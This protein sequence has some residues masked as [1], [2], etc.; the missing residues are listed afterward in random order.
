[1]ATKTKKVAA[2]PF[3]LFLILLVV[4]VYVLMGCGSSNCQLR[5]ANE[6]QSYYNTLP[7]TTSEYP[8]VIECVRIKKVPGYICSVQGNE[9]GDRESITFRRVAPPDRCKV[10][11]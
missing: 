6:L 2:P 8:K 10:H 1:M 5:A 11:K 3:R 4:M 7:S 9:D